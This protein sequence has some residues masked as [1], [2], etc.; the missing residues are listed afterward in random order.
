MNNACQS[1]VKV[2]LFIAY[3]PKSGSKK[4]NNF[5]AVEMCLYYARDAFRNWTT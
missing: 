3:N 1:T 4:M 5:A 2:L